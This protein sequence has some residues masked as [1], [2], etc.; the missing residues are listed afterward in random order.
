MSSAPS[1]CA[2]AT[3][4]IVRTDCSAPPTSMRPPEASCCTWRSSRE[5]SA[6]VTPSASSLAGSS[7]T[8]TSR[9]TP[10]TR[11]TPPTPRT[12]SSV[13]VTWLSMNHDSA[14][15]S[16]RVDATV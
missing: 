14:S 9:V 7:S 6:A 3:V 13:F 11:D 2:E 1:S 15:S 16:R 5:I 12:A 8:R 10:P 4:A